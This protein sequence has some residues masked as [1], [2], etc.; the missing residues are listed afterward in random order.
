MAAISDYYR[1][2]FLEVGYGSNTFLKMWQWLWAV[3]RGRKNYKQNERKSLD[4][5]EQF[6]CRNVDAKV[7]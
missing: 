6:V 5:L 3:G 4:G 2:W 7:C 1:L